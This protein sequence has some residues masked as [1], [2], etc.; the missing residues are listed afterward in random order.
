MIE[1]KTPQEIEDA[2]KEAGNG[3]MDPELPRK[4]YHMVVRNELETYRRGG[5]PAVFD[6]FTK[7]L[8]HIPE[9]LDRPQTR[10]LDVGASG[11]YYREIMRIAG[12]QYDYVACD[13]NPSFKKLAL[14]LYPDMKYDIGDARSLAYGNESFDIVVSGACM[15]HI[16]EYT[17]VVTE[18]A[19]VSKR[20]VVFNRTPILF[21]S[22]TRY[23]MKEAYGT[24]CV[25]IHFSEREFMMLLTFAGLVLRHFETVF[26][27]DEH[28]GYAHITYLA[29][30][31]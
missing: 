20:F 7:T 26:M 5:S 12:F 18:A 30:K 29:E 22:S 25:E 6:A 3:W 15:L 13:W 31:I 28:G 2:W 9:I 21:N 19:R 4:Q 17:K 24:P 27:N 10:L 23:F 1:L 16:R 14:E 8:L 11:G